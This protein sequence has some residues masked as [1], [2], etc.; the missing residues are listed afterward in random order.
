MEGSAK[1]GCKAVAPRVRQGGMPRQRAFRVERRAHARDIQG[2]G[3]P[4][5]VQLA[6]GHRPG[7][8]HS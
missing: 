1:H 5:G 2:L 4:A 8:C 7:I 3:T 6:Q